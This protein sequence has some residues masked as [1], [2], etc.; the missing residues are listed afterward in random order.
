MVLIL[1]VI[2]LGKITHIYLL[3]IKKIIKLLYLQIYSLPDHISHIVD[4]TVRGLVKYD[5]H[6]RTT[7]KDAIKT[8][9]VQ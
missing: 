2:F 5:P 7:A 9:K 1:V 6:S 4:S 8:F 3:F